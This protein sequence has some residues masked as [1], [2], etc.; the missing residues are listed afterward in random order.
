[1]G[2]NKYI[3]VLVFLVVN[4]SFVN[5]GTVTRSFSSGTVNAD[6]SLTVSLTID[7]AN[8]NIYAIEEHIPQGFT[9]TDKP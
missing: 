1:M 2:I 4:L 5:A 3:L 8:E 6:E 9:V 7:V